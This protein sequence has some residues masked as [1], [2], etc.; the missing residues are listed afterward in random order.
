MVSFCGI[1][2]VINNAQK[3][4]LLCEQSF[5]FILNFSSKVKGH[6]AVLVWP[7]INIIDPSNLRL[8]CC[9]RH[10]RVLAASHRA[11]ISA[12]RR[13]SPEARGGSWR[14]KQGWHKCT[15]GVVSSGSPWTAGRD[16][17]ATG[18]SR[19]WVRHRV[20]GSVRTTGARGCM[21]KA[22]IEDK[23]G[24]RV[25]VWLQINSGQGW[26]SVRRSG[27]DRIHHV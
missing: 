15:G 12:S 13:R 9:R 8:C 27:A 26:R 10:T 20:S 16:G 6:W 3:K 17:L 21:R 11:A 24:R 4:S 14:H 5:L 18:I 1:Y 25:E 23:C 19:V 2:C 7:L 22:G